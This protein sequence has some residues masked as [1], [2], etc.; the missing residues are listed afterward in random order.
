MCALSLVDVLCA[1]SWHLF[2]PAFKSLTK[3]LNETRPD[4]TLW[5]SAL[6][7]LP[8]LYSLELFLGTYI[9][10]LCL[11]SSQ[12]VVE[13]MWPH[14]HPRQFELAL[15]EK[16]CGR[17]SKIFYRSSKPFT[18]N[19]A[20]LCFSPLLSCLNSLLSINPLWRYPFQMAMDFHC[21]HLFYYCD[22]LIYWPVNSTI[23]FLLLSFLNINT[24][25][26]ASSSSLTLIFNSLL[27]SPIIFQM[28]YTFSQGSNA[29]GPTFLVADPNINK[30]A[31]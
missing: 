4:P 21:W 25:F 22:Y 16:W 24:I 13:S 10:I 7:R 3:M 6:R 12:P 19:L 27:N 8:P 14:S 26:M 29:Q 30:G 23:S 17:V 15:E 9:I 20:L 31:A 5:G 28:L 18:K 11:W 2:V 1:F